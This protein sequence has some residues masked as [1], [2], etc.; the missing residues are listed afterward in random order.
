MRYAFFGT[1]RFAAIILENL[2][3]AGNPPALLVCNPDKPTGRKN[4][5][6]PPLTKVL[7]ERHGVAI[8]QPE[9]LEIGGWKLEI[10]KL[11]GINF[12]F[13][14]AYSKIIPRD[15]LDSAKFFGIHPSLLPKYRG[16]SP[17]Q[18]VILAGENI[19]GVTIYQMDERVDHGP[20]ALQKEIS[21]EGR[22]TYLTL[23]EKLADL[24]TETFL[25][26]NKKIE[27]DSVLFKEQDHENATMTQKFKTEDGFINLEKNDPEEM[28]RKI[29]ALN[30]EP[31]VWTMMS[32]KRVKILDAEI[33]NNALKLK[34]I[35]VE[36][37]KPKNILGGN[38]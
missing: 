7:A 18:S 28:V 8:W 11:G 14:A 34:T 21:I 5:I 25:E 26:L 38:L 4:I 35:Q 1:P 15:I 33:Q 22:D 13:V 2:I 17:I 32:G 30:P 12:A 31:G 20:I 9:K 3:E 6:T 37:E 27:T 36:G 24:G 19:S 29:R 10:Q 23:E 16:A